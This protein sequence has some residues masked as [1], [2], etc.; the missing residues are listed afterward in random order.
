L[1]VPQKHKKY[2]TI[3][4]KINQFSV[5]LIKTLKLSALY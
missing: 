3:Y 5:T 4:L 1:P 2:A